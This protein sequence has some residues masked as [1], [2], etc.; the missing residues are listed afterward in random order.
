MVPFHFT[1]NHACPKHITLNVSSSSRANLLYVLDQVDIT[2][3]FCDALLAQSSNQRSCC[4]GG[5][6]LF[7][8]VLFSY[9]EVKERKTC[10][11]PSFL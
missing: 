2:S 3:H 8:G 10:L 5:G 1:W 9:C 4:G 11:I 7:I 6:I